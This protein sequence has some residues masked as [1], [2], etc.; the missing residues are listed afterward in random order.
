MCI[1][2]Q[3]YIPASTMSSLLTRWQRWDGGEVNHAGGGLAVVVLYHD[4][5]LLVYRW[6]YNFRNKYQAL[7]CIMD[8]GKLKVAVKGAP[9]V[10]Y[11][12]YKK[13][14]LSA[15]QTTPTLLFSSTG[16]RQ[17]PAG[18]GHQQGVGHYHLRVRQLL[19]G[20]LLCRH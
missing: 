4:K 5:Q 16:E 11:S 17:H 15:S 20:H 14:K 6:S 12:R 13:F 2:T 8:D 9:E 10:V 19:H 18:P 3:I 1:Y 7:A